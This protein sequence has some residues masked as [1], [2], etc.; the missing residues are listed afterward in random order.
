MLDMHV[1]SL[2]SH[3]AE[4]SIRD[5]CEQ[6]SKAGVVEIGFAEHLD[7]CQADPHCGLHDYEKYREEIL[8]GRKDFPALKLRMGVEV[9]CLPSVRKEILEYLSGKDYD[10]IL[11]AAHLVREDV[12]VSEPDG[13][14]EFFAKDGAEECYREFFELTLELVKS[15]LFDG[16]AHLDII[17]GT[18]WN[19]SRTGTGGRITAGSGRFLKG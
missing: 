7:L 18:R 19:C 10:F 16:L 14:R 4:S 13:C 2:I 11:G 9:S 1:H 8:A 15:G 12:T 17:I 3:D 5:Y 6:A